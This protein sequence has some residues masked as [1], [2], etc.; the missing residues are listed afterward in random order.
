MTLFTLTESPATFVVNDRS[1]PMATVSVRLNEELVNEARSVAAAEFRTIQGQIEFW[2]AVGRAAIENPD[3]PGPFIADVIM[4]MAEPREGL[5]PF[6][7]EG[8]LEE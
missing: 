2:A 4:A 7:P 1:L 6:V 8:H 3:L 5:E